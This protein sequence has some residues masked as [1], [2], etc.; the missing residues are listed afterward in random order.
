VFLSFRVAILL[1]ALFFS[2]IFG[3]GGRCGTLQF[4]ENIQ[5]PQKR[6]LAKLGCNPESLYGK[7]DTAKT[8][9]F[10]IYY[11]K[12]GP[13]AIKTQ[14]YIDSLKL[15]LERAYDLHK[16]SLGMNDIYGAT[17][18]WHYRQRPP[19][20][21]YPIEVIDT[22]LLRNEEGDYADVFGLTFA[23][24]ETNSKL[25]QIIM[26]NDFLY[27]ADC[28]GKLS[29]KPFSRIDGLNYSLAENWHLA[30]KVTTFHELYHAFQMP[31]LDSKY[32]L[33]EYGF[34]LE[35]SATGVEEIAVPEVDDYIGY[36]SSI[37]RNPGS[38]M[39]NSKVGDG[40]GYA[41]L[42]LFLYAELGP[43][44]DSEIWNYFSKNPKDNFSTQLA[45]L[46]NSRG[47]N[48]EELFHKYASQ[49]FYS[50][51]RAQFSPWLPLFAEDM[52]KWPD[53]TRI[54]TT[55]PKSLQ[56][57]AIDFASMSC[58]EEKP[59]IDSAMISPLNYDDFCVWVLSRL[60]E[61][62]FIPTP[63]DSIIAEKFIAY[64]NPWNPENSLTFMPLP[65]NAKGVEI[66]SAN[67]TLIKK[68]EGKP[69][70]E[71]TWKPANPPKTGI[72]LYRHFP[73][74][75]GRILIVAH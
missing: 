27:G 25:T 22:G 24:N 49:I 8:K 29:T 17:Q 65:E 71:L 50:G 9:H 3:A 57:G 32:N 33:S 67:G 28:S 31:Y 59:N 39:E 75:K 74:G 61:T 72:L 68:I 51:S 53:W 10:I 21:L 70:E 66:R 41:V 2:P 20:G 58:G 47:I 26:E 14:A 62:E 45:R 19:T 30:L 54:K 6:M 56:A 55:I 16:N 5:N 46:A 64:P 23:P 35:A 43:Q 60:L 52:P 36:I 12:T 73:Y 18:T 40:Y 37:F 15:Y 1:I 48:P 42:Y 38:S 11:T 13:H 63:P 34:W 4:A 7:V 69:G 44:F